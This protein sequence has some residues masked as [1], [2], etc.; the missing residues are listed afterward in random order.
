MTEKEHAT[1]RRDLDEAVMRSIREEIASAI[2]EA[3]REKSEKPSDFME[4]ETGSVA[5]NRKTDGIAAARM[6][7]AYA[8]AG[9]NVE[10][11][12]WLSKR[13]WDDDVG[14][15]VTR[16][17]SVGDFAG[18]GFLLPADMA[19]ELIDLF[20][21]LNV[22]RAAGARTVPMP[23]GSLTWPRLSQDAAAQYVGELTAIPTSEPK[24]GQIILTA[25]KLAGLALISNDLLRTD[26]GPDADRTVRDSLVEA[27]ANREDRAFLRDDGTNYKPKGIRYWSN[28]VIS[29]GATEEDT[30]VAALNALA[31]DNVPL[32]N[33]AWFMASRTYFALT[34]V[35]T[36]N[37]ERVFP[38]LDRNML[39][40]FP[41]FVSNNIPTNLG[42]GGNESEIYLVYMPDAVIAEMGGMEI[43]VD[44]SASIDTG[45]G[46][47][48]NLFQSD[49][50]AVRAIMR[51]DFA[52]LH[53]ESA[54]V[55][56]GV[57]WT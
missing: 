33:L 56:T 20:R 19:R 45:G 38:E 55:V 10:K 23:N 27:L 18:G 39:R 46:T 11:A 2:K 48:V 51:H 26:A 37:G 6:V 22:V 21:P 34:K 36:T 24:G 13:L 12:A 4:G 52:L 8:M 47:T 49:A 5:L 43:A 41:V 3:L 50:T 14:S 16:A 40:G 35:R 1:E 28:N 32:R 54:A 9:G 53:D 42:G 15:V 30:I 44:S 29:V 31:E 17:F 25:K 57:T 7:R